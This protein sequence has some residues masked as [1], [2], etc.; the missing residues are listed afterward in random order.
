MSKRIV[1]IPLIIS[2]FLLDYEACQDYDQDTLK[3]IACISLLKK[4]DNKIPDKNLISGHMLSCFMNI[5]E[6]TI[7]NLISNQLS[8][9]INIEQSEIDKLLDFENIQSK[10][11]KSEI[12]E[13]SKKLNSVL[14][15]LKNINEMNMPSGQS[16]RSKFSNKNTETEGNFFISILS[17]IFKLFNPNDSFL[18]LVGFFVLSYFCLK[19]LRKLCDEQKHHNNKKKGKGE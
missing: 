17:N 14:E 15:K 7:Q 18:V 13:N 5:E 11:S 1:F 12:I 6:S 10:Y 9:N 4:M 2:L 19:G 3:A 8:N 16:G